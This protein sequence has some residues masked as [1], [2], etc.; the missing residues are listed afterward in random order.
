[1]EKNA[2]EII[3]FLRTNYFSYFFGFCTI[4]LFMLKNI[5]LFFMNKNIFKVFVDV[6]SFE[7]KT[8]EYM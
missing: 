4:D 5:S 1:M 3:Y 6:Y 7:D 8:R 2:L